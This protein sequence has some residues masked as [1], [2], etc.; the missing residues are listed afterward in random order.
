MDKTE[1]ILNQIFD[2]NSEELKKFQEDN[3]HL[4][5]AYCKEWGDGSRSWRTNII[6]SLKGEFKFKLFDQNRFGAITNK[7][8]ILTY[9]KIQP[10]Y[11][12][13]DSCLFASFSCENKVYHSSKVVFQKDN[14]RKYDSI[15]KD[16]YFYIKYND[17]NYLSNVVRVKGN[18]KKCFIKKIDDTISI[19][20]CNNVP[21]AIFSNILDIQ[22]FKGAVFSNLDCLP[23]TDMNTHIQTEKK[24]LPSTHGGCCYM[25]L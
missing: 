13:Y 9:F 10:S 16:G 23:K 22:I 15:I 5:M 25:F 4:Y 8:N 2:S 1:Y 3:K 20:F 7:E 17:H 11:T 18:I 19:I 21:I 24:Q 6:S 12:K 14:T